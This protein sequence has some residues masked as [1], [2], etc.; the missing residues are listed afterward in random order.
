MKVI[1]SM[2]LVSVDQASLERG[3]E[4][5]FH[6]FLEEIDEFGLSDKIAVSTIRDVGLRDDIPL[7]IVYPDAAV[8]GPVRLEDVHTIVEEH[9][10]KGN[11]V[12]HLLALM[13]ELAPEIAWTRDRRGTLPIEKRI[14]LERAGIVNPESIED[15]IL[16]DGFQ[17]LGKALT[18]MTPAEVIAEIDKSGLQGRGGAG[19]PTGRKWSFVASTPGSPKY[20][21]CNAD[22]SEPGTFKDRLILEGDPFSIVE[23]MTIAG[24]AIGAHEGYIYIR[25]EYPRAYHLIENAIH[26]AEM[27]GLLGDHIFGTDYS[28]HIHPHAGAGAYICGEETALIESLEGKRG[29]P[30]PRPPY[31][32]TYGLFGKPT[33]VN[34]VETLANV[35]PIL[36]NGAVWYRE[37]GSPKSTGTKVYTILGNVNFTGLIEVPMGITLREVIDIYGKGMRNGKKLKLVQTGGSSGTI[38][39]AKLQD[40]PLDFDSFRNAGVSLGSGALLVCDEDTCVVDLAKVILRFFRNECCGKCT[41]CRIGTLRLYEI[42][43]QISEGKAVLSDLEV[44]QNISEAMSEVSNCGLGQTASTALRDILK[45]FREEVEMHIIDKVCPVGV[46]PIAKHESELM[47]KAG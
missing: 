38:V 3:A 13:R 30:R 33:V 46:C 22:E 6:K 47:Q 17:A 42:I 43:N 10:Y 37:V 11:I 12:P 20:V 21:I 16:N 5:V 39:P 29:M 35:P 41:P 7:V 31:P 27:L 4:E 19:F 28:F 1:R 25:G 45:Y 14:V 34:N 36:R 40:T 18:Q 15:Y 23:A 44:M 2:V 8:Y 26:Q 9:L 24:Y 32:T